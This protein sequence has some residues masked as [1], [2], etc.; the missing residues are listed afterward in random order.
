MFIYTRLKTPFVSRLLYSAMICAKSVVLCVHAKD[1][2]RLRQGLGAAG[3]QILAIE[4]G[5][6]DMLGAHGYFRC[7]HA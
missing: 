2:C 5:S 1:Y 7:K 4:N 6:K 3:P